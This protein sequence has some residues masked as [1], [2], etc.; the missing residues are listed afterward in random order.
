MLDEE[1]GNP[2]T[3]LLKIKALWWI[4]ADVFSHMVIIVTPRTKKQHGSYTLTCLEI[5]E[6]YMLGG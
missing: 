5:D 6:F 1:E 4:F 3:D 2:G